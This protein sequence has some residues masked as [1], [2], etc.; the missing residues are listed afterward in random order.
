[1]ENTNTIEP[2]AALYDQLRQPSGLTAKLKS[3]SM[4]S[5][6]KTISSW[7]IEQLGIQPYQHILEIGYG[8]GNTLNEAAKKLGTGFIAGTEE[9][10][11]YYQ[12]AYKRNKHFIDQKLMQLH[13]GSV[14][15]LPY[16]AHYFHSVY[17][18]SVYSSW[19]EPQYKFMQLNNLLKS[20][21]KLI[22]LF[23]PRSWISEKEVWNVAEK[24][25]D[26][27]MDAGLKDVR[28]SFREIRS[29]TCI[30]VVGFKE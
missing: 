10:V 1:M 8:N 5:Q 12:Q 21:G 6:N 18:T 20:G 26:E 24:I 27:Y 30:A 2:S 29:S 16:P 3:W 15:S 13:I 25:Q 9:S 11:G 17:L 4:A 19:S 7:A 22:T 14:E 28:L 23:Q